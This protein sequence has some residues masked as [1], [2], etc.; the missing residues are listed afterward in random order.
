[1]GTNLIPM[2]TLKGAI[3]YRRTCTRSSRSTTPIPPAYPTV[4]AVVTPGSWKSRRP[5]RRWSFAV[6][7]TFHA[8]KQL[9]IVGGVSYDMNEVLENDPPVTGVGVPVAQPER[10]GWNWQTAAIYSYSQ[11]GKVHADVSSRTAFLPCS[12]ATARASTNKTILDPNVQ[13]E[14]AINYEIGVDDT[15][16]PHA[17]LGVGGLLLRHPGQHPERLRR[18]QRHQLATVGVIGP[19]WQLLGL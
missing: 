5:R 7:N 1:M 17:A 10:D 2:N 11:T 6:E 13:P 9:D 19:G 3:H 16:Y 15:F 18:R 14:R 4:P 12:S 8:T